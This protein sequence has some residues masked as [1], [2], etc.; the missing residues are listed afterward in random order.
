MSVALLHFEPCFKKIDQNIFFKR[1]LKKLKK[2]V[3]VCGKPITVYLIP[4]YEKKISE[5]A[6]EKFI[7]YLKSEKVDK[8]LL[9]DSANSLSCSQKIK[10]AFLSCSGSSVIIYMVYDI[11]KK[12][13]AQKNIDLYESTIILS[14]EQPHIMKK[15]ILKLYKYVKKIKILTENPE[16]FKEL[17]SE[18][19][20]DYGFMIETCNKTEENEIFINTADYKK[21]IIFYIKR[22]KDEFSYCKNINQAVIEFL[23]E[24][25]FK[26]FNDSHIKAFINEFSPRVIKIKNND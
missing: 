11:L 5:K 21:E 13:A 10:N 18:F 7:T 3:I 24:N 6:V 14:D 25:F 23:C 12:C 9:S 26:G 20:Y 1:T 4:V 16:R 15:T 8:I 17:I 19:L 2:Q 22:I